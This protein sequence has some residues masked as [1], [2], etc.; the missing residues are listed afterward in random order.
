MSKITPTGRDVDESLDKIVGFQPGTLEAVLKATTIL[1]SPKRQSDVVTVDPAPATFERPGRY[2]KL[3]IEGE[4]LMK[5]FS[6]MLYDNGFEMYPDCAGNTVIRTIE[7]G[8]KHRAKLAF[9]EAY[10]S[11]SDD[12]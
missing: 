4:I 11:G 1:H 5:D 12:E 6:Q 8:D 2:A 7:S 10:R 9:K 3:L